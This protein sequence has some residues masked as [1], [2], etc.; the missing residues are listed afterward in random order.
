MVSSFTDYVFFF[1]MRDYAA[2]FYIFAYTIVYT[3][4]YNSKPEFGNITL[5]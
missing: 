4:V 1:E 2:L 5:Y 3:I